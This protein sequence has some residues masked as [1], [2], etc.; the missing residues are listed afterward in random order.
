MYDYKIGICVEP[1]HDDLPG[2][3]VVQEKKLSDGSLNK[4]CVGTLNATTVIDS[5][6]CW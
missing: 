6:L 3:A 1:A 2:C 5:K 4:V